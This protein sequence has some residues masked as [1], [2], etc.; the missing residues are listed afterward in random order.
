MSP[1]R[2][3]PNDLT[4]NPGSNDRKDG[5]KADFSKVTG[6]MDST[7]DRAGPDFSH[8][9]GGSASTARPADSGAGRTHTVEKGDT[10]S[11]ISRQHYGSANRWQEI[12]D[13]NRDQLDDPDL[14]QP[15]QVLRIP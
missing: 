4:L 1:T 14:I 5:P 9:T 8:V 2:K 6:G 15:G 10:L 13:A 11:A 7:A 12:F 3:D